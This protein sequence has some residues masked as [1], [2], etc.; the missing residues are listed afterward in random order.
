MALLLD[1]HAVLWW[2]DR[3]LGR[4]GAN[5]QEMVE[6]GDVPVFVS[7]VAAFEIA[8]KHA[9]GKL[10]DISWLLDGWDE[11]LANA[12]FAP[13]PVEMRHAVAV[14]TLP[15][16]HRDPFDRLLIAQGLTD[17]LTIVS[18]DATFDRYGVRRLW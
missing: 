12:R 2:F 14:A 8:T 5:A 6:N 18:I 9:I 3:A 15:L 13:L 10:P 4:L 16:H 17:D 1:T 7:S 11:R